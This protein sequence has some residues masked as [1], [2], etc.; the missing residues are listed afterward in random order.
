METLVAARLPGIATQTNICLNLTQ[1]RSTVCSACT[2]ADSQSVRLCTHV[3]KATLSKQLQLDIH[4]VV[5]RSGVHLIP[6]LPQAHQDWQELRQRIGE[7]CVLVGEDIITPTQEEV[8]LPSSTDIASALDASKSTT[9]I[10]AA[11]LNTCQQDSIR[12]L[13]EW[14]TDAVGTAVWPV[15]LP[16]AP[17]LDDCM[18]IAQVI[19]K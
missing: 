12:Q 2:R 6:L 19:S 4:N 8:K 1:V 15:N 18:G 16:H 11:D 17:T 14:L 13:D 7:V 10:R 5:S 3:K 9:S